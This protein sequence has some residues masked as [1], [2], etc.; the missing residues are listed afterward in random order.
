MFANGRF[1]NSHTSC[2]MVT[3]DGGVA[4]EVTCLSHEHIDKSSINPWQRAYNANDG[5]K[6]LCSCNYA[7]EFWEREETAYETVQLSSCHHRWKFDSTY[8]TLLPL[9]HKY[10]SHAHPCQWR[11]DIVAS[12]V[13]WD[14]VSRAKSSGSAP[15]RSGRERQKR[16]RHAYR[17][18]TIWSLPWQVI[19][20]V[21]TASSRSR[22]LWMQMA[23][24]PAVA[25]CGQS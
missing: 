23:D 12:V 21:T 18:F 13:W 25:L 5:R 17:T 3:R 20:S 9:A 24:P 7:G 22:C 14:P 19:T 8:W 10:W 1:L 15:A 6:S 4:L 16:F 2:R 11:H